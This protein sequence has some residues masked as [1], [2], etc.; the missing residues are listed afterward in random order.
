MGMNIE[1]H[2]LFPTPVIV[3]DFKRGFSQEELSFFD[4]KI[5]DIRKIHYSRN[6]LSN[7]TYVLNEPVMENLNND[8]TEMIYLF[9]KNIY[10]PA[11]DVLPYITQSWFTV[12]KENE[13]H[14]VHSHPNSF[15]SGVLYINA[16]ENYD[17]IV[18]TKPGIYNSLKINSK[19]ENSYTKNYER[20]KVKTGRIV[21][22]PSY[23]THY[24]DSKKGDN[25][26][27]SLAFN[28]FIKGTLGSRDNLTELI[29]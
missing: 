19:E 24:V 14:H 27:V 2:N 13:H 22:F 7:D 12:T 6:S 15:I 28:S 16:D 29:L 18:F 10:N 20:I 25:V 21:L 17:S 9:L 23:T 8:I 3:A 26:R 5:K 11:T 4:E 1:L